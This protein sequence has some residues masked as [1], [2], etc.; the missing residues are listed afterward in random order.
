MGLHIVEHK[1]VYINTWLNGMTQERYCP[2][3]PI[4]TVYEEW[5]QDFETVQGLYC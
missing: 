4:Q 5:L 3:L 2:T 1:G